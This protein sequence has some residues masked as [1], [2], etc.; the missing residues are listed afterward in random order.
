ML[1][2]NR[3]LLSTWSVLFLLKKLDCPNIFPKLDY[4]Y[5][6]RFFDIAVNMLLLNTCKTQPKL[7]TDERRAFVGRVWRDQFACP[8]PQRR[9]GLGRTGY[10]C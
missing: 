5:E 8:P 3:C 2:Y 4:G 9:R 1:F 7:V 6:L 10:V